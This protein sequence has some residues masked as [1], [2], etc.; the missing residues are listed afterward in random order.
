MRVAG[1]SLEGTN[2]EI[3]ADDL[4][5]NHWFRHAA[6]EGAKG[7]D[8]TTGGRV[9]LLWSREP[10]W[11]HCLLV[12]R[13]LKDINERAYY[14]CFAP[15]GTTL[16]ELA[17]V[18]GLRWTIETC[19]EMAKDEFGLDH[20]EARSWHASHRHMSLVMTALA[21]LAKLRA[22]LLRSTVTGALPSKRN[23]RSP[24]AIALA[25]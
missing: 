21:F 19:F 18:A 14:I 2:P 22:D 16:A 4:R 6:G 11:E 20:C 13:S 8:P 15:A 5:S 7:P 17:G 24:S 23:E 1:K 10:K 25:S 9:R 12:R 3:L